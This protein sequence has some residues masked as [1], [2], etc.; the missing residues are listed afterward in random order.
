MFRGV[1][2][3]DVVYVLH[4]TFA[5]FHI[6]FAIGCSVGDDVLSCGFVFAFFSSCIS[7]VHLSFEIYSWIFFFSFSFSL[8]S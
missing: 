2:F 6:T 5:V 8:P 3:V 7:C 4:I 1:T